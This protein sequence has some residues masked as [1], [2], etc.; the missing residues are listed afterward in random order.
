MHE[1]VLGVAHWSS[2]GSHCQVV[3]TEPIHSAGSLDV[4][5]AG[6]GGNADDEEEEKEEEEE[7]DENDDD[8]ELAMKMT[9]TMM[10]MTMGR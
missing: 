7:D 1:G 5:R 10:R 3:Q 9:M 4:T 2:H 6:A 8:D